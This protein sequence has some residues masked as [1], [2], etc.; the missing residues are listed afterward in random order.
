MDTENDEVDEGNTENNTKT[1]TIKPHLLRFNYGII[2]S[3]DIEEENIQ[4]EM[5]DIVQVSIHISC[6]YAFI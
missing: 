2:I 4:R 1:E 5:M 3:S 6:F